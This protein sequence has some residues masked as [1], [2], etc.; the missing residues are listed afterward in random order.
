MKSNVEILRTSWHQGVDNPNEIVCD[1]TARVMR[2][3]LP[4]D[5][6]TFCNIKRKH[7][8]E[9]NANGV[10]SVSAKAVCKDTDKFDE[11]VGKM[12]AETKAQAKVY[13]K[14]H[15]VYTCIYNWFANNANNLADL[16]ENCFNLSLHALEHVYE[17][18]NKHNGQENY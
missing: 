6:H 13:F 17:I 9:V 5:I 2:E 10:F 3:K 14:A 12:I 4:I 8:N 15:R 18:D 11:E 16:T 1:I 7:F